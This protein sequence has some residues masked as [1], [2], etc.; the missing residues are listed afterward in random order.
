[1]TKRELALKILNQRGVDTS[2]VRLTPPEW[3]A[4]FWCQ[5]RRRA[6]YVPD[7]VLDAEI[8]KAKT[9]DQN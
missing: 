1:M 4:K 7:S 2:N 6:F 5:Y 3:S 8:A 9:H